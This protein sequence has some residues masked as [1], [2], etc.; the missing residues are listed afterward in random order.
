MDLIIT[1]ATELDA[2]WIKAI[3]K[4][5]AKHIGSFNL[6]QVWDNYLIGKGSNRFSK[7]GNY[8]FCNWGYSVRKK[9]YV[10]YD[11]GILQEHKGKGIGKFFVNSIASYA[12]NHKS[13]LLL[14]CNVS[15][16]KGND[17]YKAIG[18]QLNG[19]NYTKNGIEQNVWKLI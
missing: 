16:V 14:K 7:I 8:A 12:R 5:E 6:F 9:C 11:I 18:M 17:F 19:T 15:N 3:Y 2:D 13:F 10:I 4:Q 1:Q